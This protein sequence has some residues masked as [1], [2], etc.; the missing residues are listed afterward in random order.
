MTERLDRLG[1]LEEI[2][3]GGAPLDRAY[4]VELLKPRSRTVEELVQQAIPYLR[5]GV[6]YDPRAVKKQ[7][8]KD[9][10]AVV[11]RLRRLQDVLVGAEWTTEA[12]EKSS[13]EL[14]GELEVGLGKILQP[15]RVA[16]T[17]SS[18]SP[19]M[20]DVL[21]L[22]GRERSMARIQAALEH[23]EGAPADPE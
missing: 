7:W 17:G 2:P 15:L 9:R 13:R 11:E 18:A 1:V 23:L 19:G 10:E 3:D 22:L 14:A 20:F 6:D 21:F 16:L 8:S 5:E 4:L 12:L